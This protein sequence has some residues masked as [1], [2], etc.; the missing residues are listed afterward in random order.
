L[1][2]VDAGPDLTLVGTLQAALPYNR[3]IPCYF[4]RS[5]GGAQKLGTHEFDEASGVVKVYRTRAFDEFVGDFNA[6]K[7]LIARGLQVED[8]IRK[9]LPKLKRVMD[10]DNVGEEVA[11]WVSPDPENHFWLAIFYTW[12]AWKLSTESIRAALP[13]GFTG[14]IGKARL[15]TAA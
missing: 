8:E 7:I 9:H 10:Y 4:V 1:L 6:G 3:A 2:V 5:R 13:V 14:L 11:H 12:M 15:K